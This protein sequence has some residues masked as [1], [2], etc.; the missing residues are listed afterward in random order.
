MPVPWA[1]EGLQLVQIRVLVDKKL[2]G[3]QI[4]RGVGGCTHARAH[5]YVL[6]MYV[7]A[8]LSVVVQ[9]VDTE[10][11]DI[12]SLSCRYSGVCDKGRPCHP[13]HIF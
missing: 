8:C 3:L 2:G 9:V 6:C 11:Q 5:R 7:F 10:L 13:C 4:W 12:T 1:E